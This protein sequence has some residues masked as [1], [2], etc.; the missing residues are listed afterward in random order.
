MTVRTGARKGKLE[1]N[2][3]PEVLE[4]AKLRG[5]GR[6]LVYRTAALTGL[7]RSEL[8]KVLVRYLRKPKNLPYPILDLPAEV[9]K[10]KRAAR[11]W[12]L[13]R[14]AKRLRNWVKMLP[15]RRALV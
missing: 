3:R 13:P 12:V 14:L 5:R 10:N 4:A 9:T 11:V 2:V 7:R 1:N 6:A 8:A 15:I